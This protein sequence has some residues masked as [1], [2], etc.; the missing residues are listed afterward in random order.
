MHETTSNIDKMMEQS[1]R[2]VW[3]SLNTQMSVLTTKINFIINKPKQ[4]STCVLLNFF[5]EA[6]SSK[7]SAVKPSDD[8]NNN[9]YNW[10]NNSDD[11][12]DR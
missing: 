8:A 5:H 9:C 3:Q 7:Q 4:I 10:E 6:I 1:L 12:F 11:E 2:N